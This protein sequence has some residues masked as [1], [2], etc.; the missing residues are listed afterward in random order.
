MVASAAERRVEAQQLTAAAPLLDF[1]GKR[2]TPYIAQSEGSE[3][4]LACI[5]MVAGYHGYQ[6]DLITL[7]QRYGMSLKGANLKQVIQV[8]EDIGFNARP[9]RGEIDDLPHLSLPAI[10]HWNLNHFVVLTK[11]SGGLGGKRYHIHDPARGTLALTREEVSRHFTGVA[12]DLLKSESFKPKIDRRDLRIGQLWSSM[13][14]FWQTIRQ[15]VLL[16]LVLQFVALASPFFLQISIDTV[17]PSFDRDLLLMLALGFGGLVIIDFLTDW[18]RSLILVTLSNSLS[19][20]VI[21][22]LYRHLVRLPLD[23]FEKRHVGDIIS[24]FDST[25][26]ISQLLS[27]GMIAAFIDGVMALLTLTLMFVYSG[28][29]GG[30]AVAALAIYI[31]IRLAFLQALRLRN[32]DVITTDARESSSFI[33]TVRGIAAIKAFG[34]EGNRQRLWQKT[35]ADAVNA[36]IKLGRL[37]AGFDAIGQF[38]LA[39]ERVL[40]V[41]IAIQLAF[42]AKLS[43]GMIFAFQAYKDQF[44]GAGMRLVEQAINFK[45]I[46]VHLTRIAD[47]ALSKPEDDGKQPSR[48]LPDY[49]QGIELRNIRYRYGVGEPEVLQGASLKIEP[50]EMVALVGPSGGGKTTLLKIMM[51]LFSPTY[52]EILIGGRHL[53]SFDKRRARQMIGSVAQDDELF[54]GSLAENIAFF[55][56]EIDMARVEEVAAIACIRDDINKMPMRFDTMVGDMGSVLS[57]GQKQ[58]VLLARA[59]YHKP[60]ILFVDEGTAHLDPHNEEEVLKNI[61]S[62]NI[63]TVVVAH[64]SKSIERANRVVAVMSGFAIEQSPQEQ[65]A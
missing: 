16:S 52:G 64:R 51:G 28:I 4:A 48:D 37:T 25:Q 29:L 62:L 35:K 42:D 10:L 44:L 32:L 49:S 31:V 7:R 60:P 22:N 6:T 45:I 18:L 43:I 41:Y 27:Q 34:Q 14:G 36:Q 61:K 57:G 15:V 58:R 33:E 40:F 11:I 65:H 13:S 20:Q 26:P 55:D 53:S 46:Q 56:P 8:A 3:C 17:F 47:I 38:V 21:V 19:Y 23:W 30:V 12:L 1:G 39:I 9:L 63:T 59:L 5:A 54:A 2:R 50:G 24:R